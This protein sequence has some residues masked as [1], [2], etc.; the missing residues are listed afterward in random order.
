MSV[1]NWTCAAMAACMVGVA[2]GESVAETVAKRTEAEH[3]R[4][5][6]KRG[7]IAWQ[8]ERNQFFPAQ[9]LARVAEIAQWLPPRAEAPGAPARY[10]AEWDALAATPDGKKRIGEAEKTLK[11][12]VER[13]SAAC[14]EEYQRTGN[15]GAYAVR[16]R[17]D[18]AIANLV[19]GEAL[20]NK[21]RFLAKLA[22][23]LDGVCAEPSW[24][25]PFE[26]GSGDR[27]KPLHGVHYIDLTASRTAVIVAS[28]TAWFKDRLPPATV[29]RVLDT[30]RGRIFETF[31]K[32]ARRTGE[33][34]PYCN[35]WMPDRFNW[36]AVCHNGC[37]S[38]ML[39]M[40]D[41]PRV[42]AEAIE[43]A[44]RL[45]AP[46][47]LSGF[48]D[49]GYC[50]EGMGYWNFGFGNFMKLAGQVRAATNGKVDFCKAFPR[51]KLVAAFGAKYRLDDKSSPPFADGNGC[52]D[53]L[54][55][56]LIN[57]AWPD[58]Y[59][60]EADAV[61]PLCGEYWIDGFRSFGAFRTVAPKGAKKTPLPPRDWFAHAD[62]LIARAA[63]FSFA[64]KGGSNADRHNHDDAGSYVID[65]G[66]TIYAGDPGNENYTARTFSHK[67]YESPVLNSYAH[68]VPRVAGERQGGGPAFG[69][70]VLRTEFTSDRD[71]VVY[72]L[73]GAYPA[74]VPLVKLVR[75]VTF[76]RTAR[77]VTVTD[78]VEFAEPRAFE[79]PVIAWRKPHAGADA[80]HFHI[81]QP[82]RT[83][84]LSVAVSATGGAWER[85]DEL[86]RNPG[87]TE[88]WRVAIRFREPILK[89][90]VT[91]RYTLA[92]PRQL[93]ILTP[94]ES[95]APRVNG[96]SVFGVS[97]GKPVLY[98]VP[99]TGA[100]PLAV[101]V[102]AANG[103]WPA[104]L[105][106]DPATRLLGG[107]VAAKGDYELLISASNA[108]GRA[109]RKFTL[110]VGSEICLTPPLGW[111]SW[112]CWGQEVSDEK[113]RRAAD[114]FVTSGLRDHGWSY[115]VVDDCWRTRPT[116]KEAGMKRPAW[117][118]NPSHMYGPAREA[119]GTPVSNAHFPDMKAL[120]DYIHSKGLKAGLY[121]VPG[122]LACCFT[123]GSWAYEAKDAATWAFWGYDLVKY[124]WCYGDREWQKGK[125]HAACQFKGYALMGD[126]LAKQD[127]DIVYNVCNYG[128]Y[129][130]T[131]WARRAGGHYWRTNDDLKD[132]WPLL[133]RSIDANLDVADAAGPGGWN[134]PDMLVVGPMRSNGFTH[135]RLTPNE[136]Y[137]HLTLWAMIAAPLFIG[138]DVERLDPL[139][140]ALLVN[141]EVIEIDQDPLGKAG[142]PV[143]HNADFD[144][145]T[146]PLADGSFACALFNRGPVERTIT[147]DFKQLGFPATARVR[148]VWAQKDLG[149]FT[150]SFTAS[151][152]SHAALLYRVTGGTR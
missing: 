104:G 93:G 74:K 98:Y 7:W 103:A 46:C 89:G 28:A 91:I 41:D 2:C 118:G 128:R 149:S 36:S 71:T 78:D 125:D 65:V 19:Y 8:A 77:A 122:S 54:L 23:Y 87:R 51:A 11:A 1:R 48:L 84:L 85:T 112:N 124:D 106:W 39:A 139:A 60:A 55:L 102:T 123:F 99:V 61:G 5:A 32:D 47:F 26:G 43:A 150:G 119:D 50:E 57:Q 6:G 25:A 110:K 70:K 81:V 151:V 66:G 72:D 109:E 144:V 140:R 63:P 20:E 138:C 27:Q 95:P 90:S 18:K 101:N 80:A 134:D 133:I 31:L 113:M 56:S 136:Q 131:K 82:G 137:A 92:A 107:R 14:Y 152:P 29:A 127:R 53:G 75:T 73:A 58:L 15:R 16:G 30:L 67:R 13:V 116:E 126:E 114:A 38:A 40:E 79:T 76:E 130:V 10:R 97:P 37:V 117:I 52:P 129:D 49:D 115:I 3:A 68:P 21:G 141:D 135:S 45:M 120:A 96:P 17:V 108:Q 22:E 146:R 147:A 100:K 132:T 94:A 4:G 42:R 145:W 105:T 34:T 83:D 69:A 24:V 44:E 88:P 111:N 121:S 33:T 143:V 148:D 62:V 9:N 142:R 86:V 64:V 35:W 12:S 59:A